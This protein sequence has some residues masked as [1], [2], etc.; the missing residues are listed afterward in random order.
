MNAFESQLNNLLV[1][2]LNDI[3][4][5]EEMSLKKISQGAITISEAHM[6]ECIGNQGEQSTVSTIAGCMQI[7]VPTATVAVQKLESKGY[8]TKEPCTAD[9]RRSFIRLTNEGK[10]VDRAHRIF[11]IKMVRNIS[12]Q[13]LDAEKDLLLT[14]IEKLSDFFRKQ[15][16]A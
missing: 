2:T 14:A 4:K 3:L 15:V 10:K 1:G 11:H 7:A 8:V 9:G 5:F 6:I 12:A 16:K 13:Y